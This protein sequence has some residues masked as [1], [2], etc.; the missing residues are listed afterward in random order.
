MLIDTVVNICFYLA[1]AAKVKGYVEKEIRSSLFS[2]YGDD[3]PPGL[4]GQPAV[5]SVI[6]IQASSKVLN[7]SCELTKR[8]NGEYNKVL[9]RRHVCG[10][11]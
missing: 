6:Y 4:H 11:H 1:I 5:N 2:C 10:L 8:D 9:K 3:P 7:I